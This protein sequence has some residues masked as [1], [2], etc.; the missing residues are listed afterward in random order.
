MLQLLKRLF[1]SVML[2][3]GLYHLPS[4]TPIST[5]TVPT[6]SASPIVIS[7]PSTSPTE[8]PPSSPSVT[9][10]PTSPLAP[11][12]SGKRQISPSP[13]GTSVSAVSSASPTST[14]IPSQTV[15]PSTARPTPTPFPTPLPT[16]P[17]NYGV[18]LNYDANDPDVCDVQN[19]SITKMPWIT[20]DISIYSAYINVNT[21]SSV[22]SDTS[23][24][25]AVINSNSGDV[26]ADEA[27]DPGVAQTQ[28]QLP[29][30]VATSIRLIVRVVHFPTYPYQSW[31]TCPYYYTVSVSSYGIKW[32]YTS[33]AWQDY[34]VGGNVSVKKYLCNGSMSN[35]SIFERQTPSPSRRRLHLIPQSPYN[36]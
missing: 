13:I 7:A 18:S 32:K 24:A 9:P 35:A 19:I 5:T 29:L 33:N 12:P 31:T 11:S 22:P 8:Q 36:I 6:P 14:P 10:Y 23:R 1:I 15:I 2:S 4:T 34:P 3:I 30:N 25:V 17:P 21:S 20:Q 16:P 27:L 28:I 26:L